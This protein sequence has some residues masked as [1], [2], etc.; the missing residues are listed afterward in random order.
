ML[1][2]IQK[3]LLR[4]ILLTL[5]IALLLALPSFIEASLESSLG[6]DQWRSALTQKVNENSKLRLG[7]Q[8]IYLD[9]F[10]GIVLKGVSIEDEEAS[11]HF[12]A[13]DF[14]VDLAFLPLFQGRLKQKSLH[15]SGARLQLA[16]LNSETI[17]KIKDSLFQLR[18]RFRDQSN[19]KIIPLILSK[20]QLIPFH[21]QN[22]SFS[23]PLDL[24]LSLQRLDSSSSEH[25][26]LTSLMQEREGLE[27]KNKLEEKIDL[28]IYPRKTRDRS[29]GIKEEKDW[30]LKI[31]EKESGRFEN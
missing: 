19:A 4:L 30:E 2:K 21:K 16:S 20:L 15:A 12:Y 23:T 6:L 26:K 8:G 17:Q 1:I 28:R 22:N 18:M 7:I 5:F 25:S 9:I 24:D 13:E 14:F 31:R 29:E 3:G 27:R 11:Y 10:T